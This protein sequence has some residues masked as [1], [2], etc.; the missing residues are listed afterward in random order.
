MVCRLTI[1]RPKYEAVQAE[2]KELCDR[3]DASRSELSRLV[4]EDAAAYKR[5]MDAYQ[6]P[7]ATEHQVQVRNLAIQDA[8]KGAV[9]VPLRVATLCAQVLQMSKTAAA[10]GN[11]NAASDAGAG[12]FLAEAGLGVAILNVET[13]LALIRDASFVNSTRA[14]LEPLKG[15]LG[16]RN[17]TLDAVRARL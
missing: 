12:A 8:L 7:K 16:T 10:A 15:T 13:N 11:R 14:E 4:D 2:F 9:E 17:T 1:G 6:L 3:A 5:V